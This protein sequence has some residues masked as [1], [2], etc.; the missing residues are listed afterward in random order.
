[1]SDKPDGKAVVS[2]FGTCVGADGTLS[3]ALGP[4]KENTYALESLKEY[5]VSRCWEL[6][7]KFRIT[8]LRELCYPQRSW[9]QP[10]RLGA[11]RTGARGDGQF[12]CAIPVPGGTKSVMHSPRRCFRSHCAFSIEDDRVRDP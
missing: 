6:K 1:V 4:A 3:G 8:V 5:I 7:R 10:S 11:G 9:G 2:G 12:L